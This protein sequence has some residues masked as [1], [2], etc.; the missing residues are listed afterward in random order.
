MSR[1]KFLHLLLSNN[2]CKTPLLSFL[3]LDVWKS[4]PV[5]CSKVPLKVLLESKKLTDE[6][7]MAKFL[8]QGVPIAVED[9]H[10]AI[11]CLAPADISVFR[12]V[13]QKCSSAI[14]MDQMCSE[15]YARNKVPFMLYFV[16]LGAR[17]PGDGVK[18]FM[19][20]V[21][22]KDFHA[23]KVLVR[24]FGEKM[25]GSL[26]LGHLLDTKSNLLLDAELIELLVGAGVK[27][28]G[29]TSPIT[30]VKQHLPCLDQINILCAII[31]RGVDCSQLS[32]APLHMA[33]DLAL[34]SSKILHTTY[35]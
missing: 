10:L 23:A 5:D 32:N 15:A 18:I 19:D 34:K 31:E 4:V 20:A 2:G 21:K 29:R 3:M 6:K 35:F 28:N 26:D 25:F 11:C 17:L 27:L 16:E 7:L 14:D 33:T 12:T 9:I 8:D 13:C 24:K 30:L 22:I 1:Q